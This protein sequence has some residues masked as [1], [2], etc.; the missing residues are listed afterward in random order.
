MGNLI[1]RAVQLDLVA[2]LAV[3]S[4][5]AWVGFDL[6]TT[7]RAV[8]SLFAG[9]GT[10]VIYAL[11]H[12]RDAGPDSPLARPRRRL[13]LGG[14]AVQASCLI[15]LPAW[16]A[17]ACVIPG[18]AGLGHSALKR[19]LPAAKSWGVALAV[20]LAAA[21][22]PMAASG[23]P[24]WPP[25]PKMFAFLALFVGVNAHAMDIVDLET[26]RA[27]GVRTLAVTRGREE[28]R[29]LFLGAVVAGA[30]LLM[31]ASPLRPVPEMPVALLAMGLL[32]RHAPPGGDRDRWRFFL[33]AGLALPLALRTLQQL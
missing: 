1:R 2:A 10:L 17:A 15:V 24:P 14:I 23:A 16:T 7:V 29:T 28:V 31:Y 5:V 18:L 12:L 20:A 4:L 30:I 6:P 25:D 8:V 32:L 19:R 21:T 11:D 22:L 9:A 13:V 3:A 26:D 33:D 27:N